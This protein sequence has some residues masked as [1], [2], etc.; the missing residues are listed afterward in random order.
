MIVLAVDDEELALE[1]L[2]SS[3]KKVNQD[4][5]IHD[6]TN[7]KEAL[8]WASDN[9]CDVAFLDIEMREMTGVELAK[10]IKIKNPRINIIFTTGY[11][12]YMK[13]ALDLHVSGY[14][15]KPVTKKKIASELDNLRYPVALDES[16]RLVAKTFGNFDVFCDGNHIKFKYDKTKELLAY[17]IDRSGG[18]CTNQEVMTVLFEDGEDHTSYYKAIRKDL[19]DTFSELNCEDAIV[20]QRGKIAVVPEQFSCDF[21]DWQEGDIKAINSYRGEYMIQY[22][23]GE[24]STGIM[25]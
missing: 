19:V 11:S 16:K 7:A 13:D 21:Y 6:F 18:F 12:D 4:A 8:T 1:S 23:W 24:Y 25:C 22:S 3:I 5:D 2:V 9:N 14:I 10:K 15:M 17:L 20:Q